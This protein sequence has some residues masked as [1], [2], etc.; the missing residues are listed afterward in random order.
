MASIP[1]RWTKLPGRILVGWTRSTTAC[2]V[3]VGA[4]LF[5]STNGDSKTG[6]G[7]RGWRAPSRRRASA[8]QSGRF[9]RRADRTYRAGRKRGA[10]RERGGQVPRAERCRP[11]LRG[12]LHVRVVSGLAVGDWLRDALVDRLFT[13]RSTRAQH[14]QPYARDDGGQPSSKVLDGAGVGATEPEPDFLNGVVRL[15]Y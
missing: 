8:P 1:S 12:A 6:G 2:G 10:R 5:T 13:P 4:S 15:V 7:V 11:N 3:A 14:V 9:P